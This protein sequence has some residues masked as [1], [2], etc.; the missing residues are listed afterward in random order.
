MSSNPPNA[1]DAN[2]TSAQFVE[3]EPV[4]G[5]EPLPAPACSPAA[6]P[7]GA[8]VDAPTPV[9]ETPPP[10]TGGPLLGLV[11]PLGAVVA[12][13][14]LGVLVVVVDVVVVVSLQGG[15]SSTVAVA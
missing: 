15:C 12:L 10:L 4:R 1:N 2:P 7:P 13:V 9:G 3:G 6:P 8:L 5:S 14:E 11:E